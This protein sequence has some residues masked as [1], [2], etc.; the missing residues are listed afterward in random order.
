[1]AHD[2]HWVALVHAKHWLEQVMQVLVVDC[3]KVPLGQLST[4]VIKLFAVSWIVEQDVQRSFGHDEQL[5]VEHIMHIL[6]E[7]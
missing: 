5:A 6:F 2:V 1:M 7:E 4:Q 3:K